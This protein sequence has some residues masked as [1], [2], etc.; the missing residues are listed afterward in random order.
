MNLFNVKAFKIAEEVCRSLRFA[1]KLSGTK[2]TCVRTTTTH[3]YCYFGP[4]TCLFWLDISLVSNWFAQ[5]T[6]LCSWEVSQIISYQIAIAYIYSN[7]QSPV[8]PFSMTDSKKIANA[9]GVEEYKVRYFVSSAR[10][11]DSRRLDEWNDEIIGFYW[12][13]ISFWLIAVVI[14][15]L[16]SILQV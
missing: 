14:F 8:K 1:S 16:H 12:S 3:F 15:R 11:R 13:K 5:Q 4:I 6:I 9:N 7:K 10:W 2:Q